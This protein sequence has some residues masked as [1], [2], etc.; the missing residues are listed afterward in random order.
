MGITFDKV[1]D[2]LEFALRNS[3]FPVRI[4]P[5]HI[6]VFNDKHTA[7]YTIFCYRN[8]ESPYLGISYREFHESY[9]GRS[10][11]LGNYSFKITELEEKEF[12]ILKI[13]L[14]ERNKSICIDNFDLNFFK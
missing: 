6:E 5:H 1:K 4:T 12:E 7:A 2:F 14:K 9:F 11:E 3:R 10:N 8:D 13:K